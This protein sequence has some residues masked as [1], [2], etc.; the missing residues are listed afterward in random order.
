VIELQ[1]KD[2]GTDIKKMV[3]LNLE[4]KEWIKNIKSPSHKEGIF[5]SRPKQ[6]GCSIYF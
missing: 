3:Q 1:E 4:G 5:V 6:V 2:I